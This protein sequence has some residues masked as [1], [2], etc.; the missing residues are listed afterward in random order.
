MEKEV[1]TQ[2]D[3]MMEEEM[4]R[5]LSERENVIRELESRLQ[6]LEKDGTVGELE[7]R[8]QGLEME[9]AAIEIQNVMEKEEN[10]QRMVA[11]ES[12]KILRREEFVRKKMK[13]N[14]ICKEEKSKM[15]DLK[16]K[17]L[18]CQVE[19]MIYPY[20]NIKSNRKKLRF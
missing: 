9:K 17:E 18:A 8:I 12:E 1:V 16:K 20:K 6:F 2:N 7:E 15:K 10:V 5:I 13:R 4:D 14:H 11:M 19:F 3:T